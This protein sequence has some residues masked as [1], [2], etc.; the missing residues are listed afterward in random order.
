MNNNNI[1]PA[2]QSLI[3]QIAQLS[4]ERAVLTG[5]V[6]EVAQEN[7]AMKAELTRLQGELTSKSEGE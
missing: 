6:A 1:N 4:Y 2:V 3:D 5:R 7:E